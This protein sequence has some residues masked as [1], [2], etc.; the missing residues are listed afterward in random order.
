M[1]LS[2]FRFHGAPQTPLGSLQCSPNSL[3]GIKATYFY[4]NGKVAG[5]GKRGRGKEGI[6]EKR[7]RGSEREEKEG[8]GRL[9][10]PILVCF[11]R[12][13]L[14]PGCEGPF[15]GRRKIGKGQKVW[16]KHRSRP[17]PK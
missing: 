17:P 8:K 2:R 3:A 4:G 1:H 6:E 14:F 9:A 10:M 13:R 12:H 11:R 16:E 5:K 7:R 15:R